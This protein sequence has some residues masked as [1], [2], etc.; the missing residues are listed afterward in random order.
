MSELNQIKANIARM[1]L[2]L[3]EQQEYM[4]HLLRQPLLDQIKASIAAATNITELRK[5]MNHVL[6]QCNDIP[7]DEA[8]SHKGINYKSLAVKIYLFAAS[9]NNQKRSGDATS[10]SPSKKI[11]GNDSEDAPLQGLLTWHFVPFSM[12]RF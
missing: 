11:R 7:V 6:S 5:Y 10:E 1:E 3:A 9:V 2:E 12:T 4:N 8:T